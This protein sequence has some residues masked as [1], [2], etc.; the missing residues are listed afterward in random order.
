[1][2]IFV[3]A[4][5]MHAYLA[6]GLAA[7]CVWIAWRKARRSLARSMI[8]SFIRHGPRQQPYLFETR[9]RDLV[10]RDPFSTMG[11]LW[12]ERR[13]AFVIKLW[14]DAAQPLAMPAMVTEQLGAMKQQERIPPDGIAVHRLH[15][16]DGRAIA[17][18]S[19]PPPQR[20]GEP[21]LIGIVLPADESLRQDLAA[22][23]RRTEFFVLYDGAG[24]GDAQLRNTDL[25]GWTRDGRHLTYNVGAR[26]DVEG[27]AKDVEAKLRELGR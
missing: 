5:S 16:S 19:L 24:G 6:A 3:V 11:I 17:V 8:Q 4:A 26:R 21:H 18:V 25:C 14:N 2:T 27:F 15:L 1:V 23:R 20:H 9:L 12:S 13:D 7:L 10:F 22:A